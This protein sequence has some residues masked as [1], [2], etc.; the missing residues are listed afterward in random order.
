MAEAMMVGATLNERWNAVVEGVLSHSKSTG[1]ALGLVFAEDPACVRAH[2]LKGLSALILGKSEGL[3]I[4]RQ[5]V[6][7]AE[8]HLRQGS[9]WNQD[10]HYVRAIRLWLEGRPLEAAGAFDRVLDNDPTDALAIKLAHSIRFMF[11]DKATMLAEI[12][13][14]VAAFGNNTRAAGYVKGCY[15]FALEEAG[16]YAA[17][18]RVGRRA[19][20]LAPHDAWGRH[21]VAHV[22]E[23][24]G[25]T[26]T[27]LRWMRDAA[28]WEHCNNFGYHMW[29]HLALFE[30]ERGD[31]AAVLGLYD[32]RIRADKTDDFRDISNASSLLARLEFE[33]V[34]V[35]SRWEELG[36]LAA[37]RTHEHCTIF[38]DLHYLMALAGAGQGASAMSLTGSLVSHASGYSET[39]S[40]ANEVGV[41]LADGVIA[42]HE[43]RYGAVVDRLSP[44]LPRIH[45]IG[46]S[47]AQRDVFEQMLIEAAVRGGRHGLALKLLNARIRLRGAS[48]RFAA[49][50]LASIS[51]D[52]GLRIGAMAA[53][54]IRP[55]ASHH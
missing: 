28:D 26:D 8:H 17:A 12:A 47:D 7:D 23:M 30:L 50:R 27:G 51:R 38:A 19:V 9:G 1:P 55:A 36:A 14:R 44:L 31:V 6:T 45:R 46:G 52:P 53:A 54:M 2:A 25:Q 42:F 16:D 39:A 18:E 34:D 33:G 32:S 24:T 48:N 35:G 15:A 43:G 13:P 4:A 20:E 37:N 22:Y 3:P 29:W 49:S 41:A 40:I 11:G 5:A 21:A 10:I